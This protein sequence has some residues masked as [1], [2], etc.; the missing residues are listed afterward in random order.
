MNH[1]INPYA[2]DPQFRCIACSKLN[3]QGLNLEFYED[4]DDIVC[5]WIAHPNFQGW[6][7]VVHG[8]IQSLLA[9]ETAA[10]VIFRKLQTTGVTSKM[11]T[12]YIKPL[13]TAEPITIRAHL[14]KQMRNIALVE[15]NLHN[16]AGEICTTAIC[17][18]YCNSPEKAAESGFQGCQVEQ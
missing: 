7:G 14:Q 9:D 2:N 8:G 16:A 15:V 4:N 6:R 18:Y 13:L 12:K 10:W 17:T 5:Q 1:I 11:E 3:P